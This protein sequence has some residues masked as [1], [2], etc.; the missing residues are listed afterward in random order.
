M[1][2][3]NNALDD[4]P[5]VFFGMDQEAEVSWSLLPIVTA[6]DRADLDDFEERLNRVRR[7]VLS[8]F[9]NDR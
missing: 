3:F 4:W 9:E 1:H 6:V 5:Q 8:E 2:R 7:V